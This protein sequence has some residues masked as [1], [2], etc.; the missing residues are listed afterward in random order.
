[1][2]KYQR[3]Y[4]LSH[5]PHGENW[6]RTDALAVAMPLNTFT[7][8]IF[9]AFSRVFEKVIYVRLLSTFKSK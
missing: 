4:K 2:A 3:E 1:V 5:R 8:E 7:L 6:E 9:T